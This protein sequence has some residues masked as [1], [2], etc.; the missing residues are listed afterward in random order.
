M[1]GEISILPLWSMAVIL[2]VGF[3]WHAHQIRQLQDNQTTTPSQPVYFW[4]SSARITLSPVKKEW[5]PWYQFFWEKESDDTPTDEKK[6]EAAKEKILLPQNEIRWNREQNR[7]EWRYFRTTCA[8]QSDFLIRAEDLTE[9][10]LSWLTP[11]AK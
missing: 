10:C 6:C 5:T 4:S 2:T 1:K 7:C 3:V 8:Q 11:E 9:H